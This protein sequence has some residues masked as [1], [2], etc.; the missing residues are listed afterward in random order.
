MFGVDRLRVSVGTRGVQQLV[1]IPFMRLIQ[2]DAGLFSSPDND[3][4][5]AT[6]TPGA[7]HRRSALAGLACLGGNQR[8]W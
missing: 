7:H 8:R 2:R 6:P 5:G 3:L 1:E 4:A